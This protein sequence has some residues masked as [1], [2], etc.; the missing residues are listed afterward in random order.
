MFPLPPGEGKW[1]RRLRVAVDGVGRE[2]RQADGD[3]LGALGLGGAVADPLAGLGDDGL[4]RAHVQLAAL[5]L[6]AQHALDDDEMRIAPRVDQRSLSLY[7][8]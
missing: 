6:H 2:G 4:A 1:P 3:V 8:G 5:V 7:R